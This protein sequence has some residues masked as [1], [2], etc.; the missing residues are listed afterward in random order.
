M[1]CSCPIVLPAVAAPAGRSRAARALPG[2]LGLLWLLAAG[3][4]LAVQLGFEAGRISHDSV[5]RLPDGREFNRD[6]GTL[7]AAVLQL[8]WPLQALEEEAVV[9]MK[10][11]AQKPTPQPAIRPLYEPLH[12][13]PFEMLRKPTTPAPQR[14]RSLPTQRQVS[15]VSPHKTWR[16]STA[17]STVRRSR[18][19]RPAPQSRCKPLSMRTTG[20]L[21]RQTV[22]TTM[23]FSPHAINT[24]P[25]ASRA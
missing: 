22:W 9:E 15:A 17:R 19:S 25:W 6:T 16:P 12:W 11:Q 18:A 1:A 7:D 10:A 5:E 24:P 8:R 13:R 23:T 21:L 3:P 14:R 4:A 2:L 20:F